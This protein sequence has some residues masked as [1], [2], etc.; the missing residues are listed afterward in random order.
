MRAS[1]LTLAALTLVGGV[2]ATA[3][4][5]EITLSKAPVP[6]HC[7]L[8]SKLSARELPQGCP[9]AKSAIANPAMLGAA[10]IN[11][12]FAFNSAD[13]GPDARA[14]LDS[15]VAKTFRFLEPDQFLLTGHTDGVGS[16]EFNLDLSKRRASAVVA[17]LTSKQGVAST[18]LEARGRGKAELVD[19]NDPTAAVNRRVHI[20][21]RVQ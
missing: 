8:I 20:E 4:A 1:I 5:G 6:G 9:E 18:Q 13:I 11:V 17:Y 19:A 21:R 3:S 16:D 10:D 14:I 7:L 15:D 2:A 12:P